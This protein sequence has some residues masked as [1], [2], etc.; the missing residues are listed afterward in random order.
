MSAPLER[1]WRVVDEP[2]R[3]KET[4]FCPKCKQRRPTV[5]FWGAAVLD[6]PR[7]P[8]V[9]DRCCAECGTVL[10]RTQV[11]PARRVA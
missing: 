9:E 4:R 1:E 11:H 2:A 5:T 3:Q 7:S 8:R 6:D 10:A